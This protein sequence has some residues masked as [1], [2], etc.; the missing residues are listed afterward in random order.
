MWLELR[1]ALLAHRPPLFFFFTL[2]SKPRRRDM[3]DMRWRQTGMR[4]EA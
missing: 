3:P 2:G 1:I 4:A